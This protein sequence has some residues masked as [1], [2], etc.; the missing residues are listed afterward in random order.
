MADPDNTPSGLDL[1]IAID[2]GHED[3]IQSILS[4]HPNLLSYQHSKHYLE[5]AYWHGVTPLM[6]A[7]RKGRN[8]LVGQLLA[9]G[10]SVDVGAAPCVAGYCGKNV[11]WFVPMLDETIQIGSMLLAQ[12]ADPT[13]LDL[14]TNNSV[15]IRA[16]E[17]R[18]IAWVRLLLPH[19][20]VDA[21]NHKNK[22]EQTAL[23]NASRTGL[24]DIVGE[25]IDAG[26]NP[27]VCGLSDKVTPLSMARFY[28]HHDVVE[29]LE[30][31]LEQQVAPFALINC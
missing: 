28:G 25:L 13:S 11:L 4:D 17:A 24:G 5:R 19:L 9:L 16:V 29:K 7:A 21:I 12:G 30:A 20:S 31:A 22:L 18:S 2:D 26:A 10:A 6:A 27:G 1:L 14:R 15:L 8:R 3:N 23:L